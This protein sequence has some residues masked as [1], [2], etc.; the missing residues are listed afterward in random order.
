MIEFLEKAKSR[1][2]ELELGENVVVIG[3]GNTAMDVARAAKRIPGVENVRLVYRRN[4]RYMPAEEEELVFA[5]EDGVEFMELLSPGK[6]HEGSLTC[7]VMALGA[8]D[9]SGRR[10]PEPTGETVEVPATSVIVAVGEKVE[11]GLFESAGV[12][13]TDRG[14]PAVSANLASNVEGVWV[15]GDARRGPATIVE[16]IADAAVVAASISGC[17]FNGQSAQ[18]IDPEYGRAL[19]TRG[20]VAHDCGHCTPTRCL[21]CPTVC[22]ACVEVCPNRANVAVR[23]PGMRQRQI[24]HVDGMCN[25]CGNCAV[26]CPYSEGRPYK[27]KLTVFWGEED[28]E[29]S[30]NEGFLEVD[31]GVKVRLDGQVAVFDPDDGD[32]GLPD[33]VRRTI[34]AVRRDY[35]Y[36]LCR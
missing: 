13:L 35:A 16:A 23:V 7:D 20:D 25:E 24:V 1:P 10:R 21:G 11:C 5:L 17:D 3:G 29:N 22:E 32:C 18:N 27:D 26:F 34:Q 28:F 12:E 14:I 6:L 15:S 4:R 9:A 33:G 31:G 19:A 30:E 8:P 36:L 2:S